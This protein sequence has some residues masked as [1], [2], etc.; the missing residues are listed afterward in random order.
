[1]S[2]PPPAWPPQP[3]VPSPYGAPRSNGNA[4]LI[5]I[6]GILSIV[7]GGCGIILGPIAWVMGNS[8]LASGT[9]DPSQ[10]GQVNAGRI[11]GIIGTILSVLII[12][13]YIAL[14]SLGIAGAH[15]PGAFGTTPVPTSNP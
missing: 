10:I 11:C 15:H 7:F 4:T 14:F 3:G 6:L 5:L 1:M 2:T 9:V 13:G 8:A 12:I